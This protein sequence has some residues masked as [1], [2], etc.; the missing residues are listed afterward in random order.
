[1]PCQ[2]TEITVPEGKLR[3]TRHYQDVIDG[4]EP[5]ARF[6]VGPPVWTLNGEEITEERALDLAYEARWPDAA[7]WRP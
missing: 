5:V 1:M 7:R 4:L 6:P 3:V 2:W